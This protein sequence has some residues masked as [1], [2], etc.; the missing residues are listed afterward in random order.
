MVM[1]DSFFSKNVEHESAW[2]D[3]LAICSI[4]GRPKSGFAQNSLIWTKMW[5]LVNWLYD[6][7][8]LHKCCCS[9]LIWCLVDHKW[10]LVKDVNEIVD[11]VGHSHLKMQKRQGVKGIMIKWLSPAAGQWRPADE[12]LHWPEGKTILS[13]PYQVHELRSCGCYGKRLCCTEQRCWA[14]KMPPSFGDHFSVN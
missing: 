8:Q 1:L 9:S 12:A 6:E 5:F 11:S 7:Y 3:K 10:W 13:F 2:T 14:E 4:H